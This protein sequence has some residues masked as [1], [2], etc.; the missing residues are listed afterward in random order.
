MARRHNKGVTGNR[1][2]TPRLQIAV[3]FNDRVARI[4]AHVAGLE[5]FFAQAGQ[6]LVQLPLTPLVQTTKIAE[7]VNRARANDPDYVPPDFSKWCQILTPRGVDPDEL[8]RALHALPE[9]QTAYVMRPGSPPVDPGQNPLSG[10]QGYLDAAPN[11]IDALY[12]W[13]LNLPGSDG[14]GINIIDVE[15][16]WDLNHQDLVAANI[17]LISGVNDAY[18]FHGTSVLGEMLMVDNTIGGVGIAPSSTGRVVSQWRTTTS[19]NTADAILDAAAHLS[20]GDVIIIEAQE[21]DPVSGTYYWPVEIAD[22]TYDAIRLVTAI[23][24]VVAEA[25]CNGGYA[26]DTYANLSGKQIFNRN[27][28]DFRDSG[29]IMVGAGSS[30]SPHTRLS[31]SNYGS[32]IDCYGWGEN[33]TSTTTTNTTAVG[34][35]NSS[36]TMS[37]SGTSGATPIVTGAAV[38]VQAMA[39]AAL[40]YRFSPLELRR[41]LVANGTPSAT[42]STDL[43]GVMPN[44]RAIITNNAL[45]L[46]PDIYIRDY[47]GDT[48]N[49]TTGIVSA[50]PDI[51]VVNAAVANPQAA[52]GQGSG[53]ENDPSL[54][55]AVLAGQDNFVYVRLLNRGGAVADNVSINVYWSPPA[56]LINPAQW[57]LIGTTEAAAV[58]TGKVLTVANGLTWPSALIP[59]PGHYCFIAVAGNALDPMPNLSSFTTFD[60]YV[61][62]VENNNNVAWHNFNVIAGPPSAGKPPG[63]HKLQ[64]AVSGAF[65]TSHEFQLEAI[66]HLPKGSRAFID[67]PASLAQVLRFRPTEVVNDPKRLKGRLPLNPA[68]VQRLGVVILQARSTH[69]CQLFV[70]IPQQ[71]RSSSYEFAIRQLYHGTEVGRVTWLFR[72]RDQNSGP[73]KKR[74]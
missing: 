3:R 67:M 40:G 46:L 65:D 53:T 64:F 72:G 12:G 15:Q 42:P 55:Q 60:Q 38:V 13:A 8:V 22:A 1:E 57:N 2:P 34:T 18:Q 25:G 54:S 44:L 27:S 41:I 62:F 49:P 74:R 10:N 51:I 50:S 24:I 6:P 20:F 16:G 28:P 30:A 23:G 58:P 48:G 39:Q 11:G 69:Q 66:G 9:V 43:I 37:F 47:V 68:G 52:Y 70:S 7:L 33:I 56:T 36:Y 5:K 14:A 32:R 45:N 71:D 21:T 73:V 31:F 17:V 29:A 26:L 59:A 63:F 4:P 61:E 35:D 19:Y